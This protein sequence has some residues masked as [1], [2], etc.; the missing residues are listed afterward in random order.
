[1]LHGCGGGS[2]QPS[3]AQATAAKNQAAAKAAT[4]ATAAT[5][6]S[7]DDGP[8]YGGAIATKTTTPASQQPPPPPKQATSSDDGPDYSGAVA[9]SAP[10]PPP[11][12][13]STSK[14]DTEAQTK[15]GRTR[16]NARPKDVTDWKRDDYYS[17]KHDG[18]RQLISAVTFL[19]QRFAG[20][21]SA[22]ELLAKLI[23]SP[24]DDPFLGPTSG[25]ASKNAKSWNSQLAE[26][27]VSALAANRTARA[28]RTLEE[29]VSGDLRTLEAQAAAEAALRAIAMQPDSEGND[30]LMRVITAKQVVA[31]NVNA[32]TLQA[33]AVELVAN[34]TET[35]R[36][37]VAECMNSGDIPQP[38][39]D[40]LWAHLKEPR[41]E[42]VAAQ[43]TLYQNEQ[44]DQAVLDHLDNWF[45]TLSNGCFSRLSGVPA[46]VEKR[47]TV[48]VST[49]SVSPRAA[50]N[51]LWNNEFA[52]AVEHR[53]AGIDTLETGKRLLSLAASLPNSVAREALLRVLM[54]HRDED[55]KPL[56]AEVAEPGV[57][58]VLK[59]L[60]RKDQAT[61]DTDAA[62]SSAKAGKMATTLKARQEQDKIGARW[63]T[64]SEQVL[65]SLC[66][67]FR[68]AA[69][70]SVELDD[71][72]VKLHHGAE[73]IV[74]CRF[75]W[76]D[77]S[78][79]DSDGGA[80][81]PLHVRYARSEH[82]AQPAKVLAY[83]RRQ[84][85]NARE[86][87][88]KDGVWLDSVGPASD[89][90]SSRSVDV[91]LTRPSRNVSEMTSQEQRV[92]VDVL[93]VECPK[94]GD[95]QAD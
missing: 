7:S 33:V 68:K 94:I 13:S 70:A 22:A 39:H 76:P 1:M 86:W 73:G 60:P 42:N 77:R 87:I 28:R 74:A 43:I 88:L 61:T 4:T 85:P 9:S 84:V 62:R 23:E 25:T 81:T 47:A 44:T 34:A 17:A 32:E 54:I 21:E 53:L 52:S 2:S 30:I 27:I 41:P 50:V 93:V 10:A 48:G 40:R 46:K 14:T 45:L 59:R 6:T 58:L 65:R 8:D 26:A 15:A 31:A 36:M 83:Y 80:T 64:C 19:G 79:R 16:S 63:L 91:L 78:A 75:D 24:T 5:Q 57:L 69:A 92:I 72:G 49:L 90:K 3:K 71:L 11:P 82:H 95:K 55:P 38:V 20:N 66:T 51:R 18:D 89:G 67:R 35:V 29:I 37:H 12:S 56:D